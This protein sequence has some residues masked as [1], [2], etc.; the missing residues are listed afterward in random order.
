VVVAI[1]ISL[2]QIA[3]GYIHAKSQML[4][5]SVMCLNGYYQVAQAFTITQLTKHQRQ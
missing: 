3:S 5:F 1:G 4:P 2:A